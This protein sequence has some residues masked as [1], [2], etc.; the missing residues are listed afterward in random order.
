MKPDWKDAPEWADFR[1][2]DRDSQWHWYECKPVIDNS[3]AWTVNSG[4]VQRFLIKNWQ[5]TLE[6][7]PK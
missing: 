7:R 3:S 4:R 6:E 5:D 1:A 2:M